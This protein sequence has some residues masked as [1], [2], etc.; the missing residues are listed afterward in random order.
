MVADCPTFAIGIYPAAYWCFWLFLLPKIQDVKGTTR[1]RTQSKNNVK[2]CLLR[3]YATL[4]KE[5]T[6]TNYNYLYSLLAGWLVCSYHDT[7]SLYYR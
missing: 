7:P 6:S 2:V 1:S 5:Y 3:Q 4:P